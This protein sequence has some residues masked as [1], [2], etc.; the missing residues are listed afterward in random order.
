MQDTIF[1]QQMEAARKRWET[2]FEQVNALPTKAPLLFECL[3]ELSISTQE[4]EVAAEQLRQQN[5]ELTFSRVEIEKER[6]RYLEL[7]EFAP[8]GYLVTDGRGNIREANRTAADLLRLHQD[9]LAHK[10]LALFVSK[11]ERPAFYQRLTE[12]DLGVQKTVQDWEIGLAPRQGPPF[13]ASLTISALR[14]AKGR[15]ASLRWL[16]HDITPRRR[17]EEALK[18]SEERFRVFMQNLP[19]I[20]YMKDVNGRYVFINTV[21]EKMFGKSLDEWIGKTDQDLGLTVVGNH[22]SEHHRV[23]KRRKVLQT[24]TTISQEDGC[25]Y[26]LAN[27]FPVPD[28]TGTPM[29]VGVIAIDIT[30]QKKTEEALRKSEKAL[31]RSQE[32]LRALAA[33]LL[34]AHEEERR[35]LS[36]ELHDDLNQQL[37]LLTIKVESLEK[38]LPSSPDLIRTELG[39]LRK[40]AEELSDAVHRLAY[41]LH[42]AILDDLGLT[43]ALQSFVRD[44]A[45][46]EKIEVKFTHQKLPD[47]LPPEIAYCLYRVTQESLRNV[48]RHARASRASV[49][50]KK[51]QQGISV[52]IKDLGVG[53]DP[54]STR[55]HGGLG[56]ISMEE[57]VRTVGGKLYLK[58]RPGHGTEVVAS[59]PL[60]ERMT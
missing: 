11:K 17:V 24:V 35:R 40:A 60:P 25:H 19:G 44:F 59:I 46:R 57:R 56:I 10:P 23:L 38:E 14:D 58:S 5:E 32:E 42:P 15:L 8:D 45:L 39:D 9:L 33:R 22:K 43:V 48:A 31:Q 7:F 53:F 50:L 28:K 49:T 41:Q 12:L 13:Q 4:L 27:R 55:G 51:A 54:D 2:L 36:R 26:W 52:S 16:V 30:A 37:A 3:E 47:S 34:S 6:Q 1:G 21:V 29:M 20:A 18:E